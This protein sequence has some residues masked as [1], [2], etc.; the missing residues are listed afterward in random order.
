MGLGLKPLGLGLVNQGFGNFLERP[1]GNQV[2]LELGNLAGNYL[3]PLKSGTRGGTEMVLCLSQGLEFRVPIITRGVPG[4]KLGINSSGQMGILWGAKS[5]I[6]IH[7]PL[8]LTRSFPR[9]KAPNSFN[10]SHYYSPYFWRLTLKVWS[11]KFQVN[12]G[13]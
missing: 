1:G 13:A 12:S 8:K 4:I 11:K 2:N 7:F 10:Y 6:L 3:G 9:C 5:K